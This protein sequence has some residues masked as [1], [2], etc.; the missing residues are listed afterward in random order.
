MSRDYLNTGRNPAE[1][2][3]PERVLPR[4]ETPFR[5]E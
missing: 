3:A 5:D 4:G 1:I 2:Y